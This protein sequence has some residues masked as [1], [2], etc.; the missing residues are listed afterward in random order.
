LPTGPAA[1]GAW[2]AA[3]PTSAI[4]PGDRVATL[5]W[6]H[7]A[8]LETY[9]GIPL[10]GGV[11]HTLN[12]RLHPQELAYIVNH[13]G[14]RAVLVDETLLPLWEQVRPH[15]NVKTTI[16]MGATK[17]IPDGYIDYETLLAQSEPRPICPNPTRATRS[18]CAT[19]PAPP[20]RRKAS[21][22]RTRAH[23]PHLRPLDGGRSWAYRSRRRAA[24]RA[25]VPRQ[26]VGHA[27]SP[28]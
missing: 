10:I 7:G 13:A 5:A 1:P 8:H 22:T 28:R 19:P 23:A 21:S 24:G 18:R 3:S 15:V 4:R 9:F 11:L 14:D 16:V 26:R 6:N 2:R 12:L 20:A 25:D 27:R 17:P